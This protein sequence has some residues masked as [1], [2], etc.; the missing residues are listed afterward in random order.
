MFKSIHE[1]KPFLLEYVHENE[2]VYLAPSKIAKDGIS[3]TVEVVYQTVNNAQNN[4]DFKSTDFDIN[5][6]LE[7]GAYGMLS[8]TYVSTM[9][10]MNFADAFQNLKIEKDV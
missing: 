3:Q 4:K 9:S 2:G 5:N 10:D 1:K 7:I 8:P 6:I